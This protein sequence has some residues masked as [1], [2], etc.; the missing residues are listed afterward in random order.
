VRFTF[1]LDC[2]SKFLGEVLNSMLLIADILNIVRM[3]SREPVGSK[4]DFASLR[5][6]VS[7]TRQNSFQSKDNQKPGVGRELSPRVNLLGSGRDFKIYTPLR[8]EKRE[9]SPLSSRRNSCAQ[10]QI[11]PIRS[12]ESLISRQPSKT[13][14]LTSSKGTRKS[15][16]KPASPINNKPDIKKLDLNLLEKRQ[17]SPKPLHKVAETEPSPRKNHIQKSNSTQFDKSKIVRDKSPGTRAKVIPRDKSPNLRDKSPNLRDKS[18]NLRDKSPIKPPPKVEARPKSPINRTKSPSNLVKTV[19]SRAK[20][21]VNSVKRSG[22]VSPTNYTKS[23]VNKVKSPTCAT[24]ARTVAKTTTSMSRTASK[25]KPT[26]SDASPPSKSIARKASSPMLPTTSRNILTSSQEISPKIL[27]KSGKIKDKIRAEARVLQAINSNSQSKNF[28]RTVAKVLQR[29][30]KR[31]IQAS[32][33]NIYSEQQF[34]W[35]YEQMKLRDFS[36]IHKKTLFNGWYNWLKQKKEK[37]LN[38]EEMAARHYNLQLIINA[39][40]NWIDFYQNRK[41]KPEDRSKIE[42]IDSILMSFNLP[43]IANDTNVSD[44]SRLYDESPLRLNISHIRQ[45]ISYTE[46]PDRKGN[47]LSISPLA[48]PKRKYSLGCFDNTAVSSTQ[49]EEAFKPRVKPGR[50]SSSVNLYIVVIRNS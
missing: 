48:T 2:H 11:S 8:Q 6:S 44:N 39:F 33:A 27:S 45:E 38:K 36:K 47:I 9:T 3:N 37:Q 4:S 23:P 41:L 17:P 10:K 16:T 12:I 20:S 29:Y 21:P 15:Y 14:D 1:S 18:P 13:Q 24:K 7:S 31:N 19:S 50:S 34:R 32:F 46:E 35:E 40:S 28:A 43:S 49:K 5:S 25:M 42:E 26:E 22:G 30:I